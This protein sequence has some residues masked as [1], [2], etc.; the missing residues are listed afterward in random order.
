[1]WNA[2]STSAVLALL[3]ILA[4]PASVLAAVTVESTIN[5]DIYVTIDFSGIDPI[6]YA[7]I[8]ANTQRFNATTI[9]QIIMQNLAEKNLRR[10]AWGYAPID[11]NDTEGSVRVAFHL[12]GSDI[13]SFT[14]DKASM[15]RTYRVSTD[16]RKFRVNLADGFSV[17]FAQYFGTS[18]SQWQRTNRTD[19][20]GV[21]PAYQYESLGQNFFKMSFHFIL[22][23]TATNVQAAEDTITYEAPAYAEDIFLNSPLLILSVVMAVSTIIVVYR[24]A[25][26]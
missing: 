26:V 1:V 2:A 17:D 23:T 14:V 10:V 21:H 20:L 7:S 19:A 4:F 12:G 8:R 6:T 11:Y 15:V 5:Q 16:W 24:K 18:V 25:R 9:P 3:A 22:P 13:I